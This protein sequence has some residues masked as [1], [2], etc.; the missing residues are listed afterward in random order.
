MFDLSNPGVRTIRS[1]MGGGWAIPI[2]DDGEAA[3]EGFFG[4]PP[5][6]IQPLG[7]L[8]GYIVEPNEAADLAEHLRDAGVAW[9]VSA[10]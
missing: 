3:L 7:N 2:N 1:P 6:T 10:N 9:T 4:E 8:Q 5:Y